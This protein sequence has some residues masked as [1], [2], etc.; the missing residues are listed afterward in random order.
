MAI[1]IALRHVAQARAA[2]A[3]FAGQGIDVLL[4]GLA[5]LVMA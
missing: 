2:T 5:L 4:I 3:V 1:P